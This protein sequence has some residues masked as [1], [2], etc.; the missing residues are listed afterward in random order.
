M[1]APTTTACESQPRL[2]RARLPA[3]AGRRREDQRRDALGIAR[4]IAQAPRTRRY[5]TPQITA[6]STPRA[7]EHG[8]ELP[9]VVVE[10]ELA[11]AILQPEPMSPHRE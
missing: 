4:R 11:D 5:D 7:L 1:R 2:L 3:G 10:P 8:V 6:R 9:D